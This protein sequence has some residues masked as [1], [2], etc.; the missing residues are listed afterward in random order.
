MSQITRSKFGSGIKRTTK[1]RPPRLSPQEL[2]GA[3]RGLL[4]ERR[5]VGTCFDKLAGSFMAF[6]RLA[7][8]Q[9]YLRLLDPSDR[10]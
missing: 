7:L 8:V 1:A 9:H 2:R 4:K 5:R 10:T 3:V 6:V